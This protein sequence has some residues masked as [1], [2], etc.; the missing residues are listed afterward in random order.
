M[1]LD[2]RLDGDVI[3]TIDEQVL[4]VS[5]QTARGT[6]SAAG[7]APGDGVVDL[8]IDRVAAGGPP[9]LDQIEA[10]ALE[11]QRARQPEGTKIGFAPTEVPTPVA[12]DQGFHD[13]TLRPGGV[14]RERSARPI[15]QA[16]ARDLAAGLDPGDTEALNARI[17]A[18][19]EHGDADR[20]IKE[21]KATITDPT[22]EDGRT[23]PTLPPPA[24]APS[25]LEAVGGTSPEDTPGEG[26]PTESTGGSTGTEPG[27]G[28]TETG[29]T[30][31][32]SL[33]GGLSLGNGGNRT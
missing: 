23:E 26:T 29:S 16:P 27:T 18:F 20:A 25:P 13:E 5:L 24:P 1:P 10:Q 15:N 9:R 21:N 12:A 33:G 30:G 8:I 11:E 7:L 6:V 31:A 2:I 19:N 22:A 17:E 3:A 32:G 28:G 14:D 4:G